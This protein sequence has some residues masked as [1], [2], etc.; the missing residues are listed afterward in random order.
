MRA[1]S[2]RICL[3]L[4]DLM[5]ASTIGR[6]R[7]RASA[8]LI[9]AAALAGGCG[10]PANQPQAAGDAAAGRA[11]LERHQCG[12]CHD[13]P[14][15]PQATGVVGPPLAAYSRRVYIAGKLPQQEDL[16]ARWIRDAPSFA[17][18][19]AMPAVAVTATEARDIVAYLYRLE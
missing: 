1:T 6:S 3:P 10:Q 15:V 11:A 12:A 18:Q 2:P 7:R 14:G 9:A 16:L 8:L 17:P 19:T 13:I 5:R 4:T